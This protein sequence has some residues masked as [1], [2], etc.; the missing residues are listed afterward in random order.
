MINNFEKLLTQSGG[1]FEGHT[2]FKN[3]YHG[4]GWVEKGFI[5]RKPRILDLVTILQ[6]EMI[7]KS[8]PDVD[9]IVGPIVNGSI[10]ASFVAKHLGKEFAIT[11]GKNEEIEFHRMYIP[12]PPKKV[13]LVEDLIFT[14]T[15]VKA[16]IDFLRY[17]G[18]EVLGVSVWI[19][20]LKGEINK[21]KVISLLEQPPFDLYKPEECL[22]C[23]KHAPVM[24]ND[25]RE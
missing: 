17:K 1:L 12:K 18:F 2:V 21:T 3:G 8:F 13:V 16:N 9:L 23:I 19:N 11:V 6:A 25:I 4:D 5:I 7:A 20:R 15:D 24:Y 22:L 14:G 10:V